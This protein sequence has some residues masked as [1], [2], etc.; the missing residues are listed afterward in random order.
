MNDKKQII[1]D[2]EVQITVYVANGEYS[3]SD[4]KWINRRYRMSMVDYEAVKHIL[5]HLHDVYCGNTTV[6]ES[7]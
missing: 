5:K 1:N 4:E 7:E 3:A 2:E 6:D